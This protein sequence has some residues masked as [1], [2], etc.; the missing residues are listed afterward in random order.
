MKVQEDRKRLDSIK[1]DVWSYARMWRPNTFSLG[2]SVF[3]SDLEEIPEY[4]RF[5]KS[6]FFSRDFAEAEKK[7]A[8][9]LILV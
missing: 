8:S 5:H 1:S 2:S 4:P 6:V 3:F 7:D 9:H